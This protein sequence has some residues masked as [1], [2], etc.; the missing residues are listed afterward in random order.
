MKSEIL[1]PEVVDT[2]FWYDGPVL[3]SA[4]ILGQLRLV[5]LIDFGDGANTYMVSSPSEAQMKG[6]AENRVPLRDVS[7]TGPFYRMTIADFTAKTILE[8]VEG[9]PEDMLPDPGVLLSL[10]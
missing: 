7:D 4:Y 3:Y 5:T 1:A 8:E 9:W 6:M 2:F 10:D